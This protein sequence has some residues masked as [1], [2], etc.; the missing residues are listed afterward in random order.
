MSILH[1]RGHF[2]LPWHK[3]LDYRCMEKD[4]SPPVRDKIEREAYRFAVE[5]MMPTEVFSDDVRNRETSIDTIDYLGGFYQA[6]LEATSIRYAQVHP[7]YCAI[8]VVAPGEASKP[9]DMHMN[10]LFAD[11]VKQTANIVNGDSQDNR[12]L[13]IKYFVRSTRFNRY[14]RPGTEIHDDNPVFQTWEAGERIQT[15]LRASHFGSSSSQTYNA[16]CMPLGRSGKLLVLLWHE[17]PEPRIS[18]EC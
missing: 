3:G 13:M 18:F 7:G 6:S 8:M 10:Q 1:E 9:T 16:E 4:M 15:E 2:V 12:R 14:F 5:I 17:D 11:A